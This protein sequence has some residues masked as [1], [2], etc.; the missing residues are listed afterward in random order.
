MINWVTK[1]GREFFHHSK[2]KVCFVYRSVTYN[3]HAVSK[4]PNTKLSLE[5][6]CCAA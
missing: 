4:R 1:V 6:E 5:R 2:F 3:A